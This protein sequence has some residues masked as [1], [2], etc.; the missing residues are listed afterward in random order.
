MH[1]NE[2]IV[3]IEKI[4]L[5][6]YNKKCYHI[7]YFRLLLSRVHY[8]E[9]VDLK[10]KR[11]FSDFLT[12][13]N[14]CCK[15]KKNKKVKIFKKKNFFQL[16]I[17]LKWNWN[18]KKCTSIHKWLKLFFDVCDFAGIFTF[19]VTFFYLLLFVNNFLVKLIFWKKVKIQL[20]KVNQLLSR[21]LITPPL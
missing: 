21:V 1:I 13:K 16:K 10:K 6:S 20:S 12:K 5:S 2:N 3:K 14:G 9:M 18:M 7:P 19:L 17:F 4:I 11:C 15:L 8:E